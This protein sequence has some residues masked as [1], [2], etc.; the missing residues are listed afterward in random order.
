MSKQVLSIGDVVT[1]LFPVH[2]PAGHEQQGYRPAVVVGVPAVLGEPRFPV[3]LLAP[4]TTDR[5]QEWAKSSPAL[6][7]RFAQGTA[8]LGSPSLCL[9]DQVRAVSVERLRVYRG[10]LSANEYEPIREGLKRILQ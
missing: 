1:V 7:P 10:T 3:L 5:G 2:D 6:Y 4:V 9:L 8:G